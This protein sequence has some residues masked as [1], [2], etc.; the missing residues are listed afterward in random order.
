M[1]VDRGATAV[2]ARYIQPAL[3]TSFQG[4]QAPAK[5]REEYL[6]TSFPGRSIVALRPEARH[7]LL[8]S[9]EAFCFGY[10]ARTF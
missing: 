10:L 5:V 1:Y 2:V 7:E 9:H 6:R 4:D 3:L 8:A